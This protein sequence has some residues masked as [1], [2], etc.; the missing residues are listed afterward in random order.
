MKKR[1]LERVP[2][3]LRSSGRVHL[4]KG[5]RSTK[6]GVHRSTGTE[7][8]ITRR[9][10][11]DTEKKPSAASKHTSKKRRSARAGVRMGFKFNRK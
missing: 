5:G 1:W 10:L 9:T 8:R 6:L 2:T 4:E 3:I 7:C 11:K